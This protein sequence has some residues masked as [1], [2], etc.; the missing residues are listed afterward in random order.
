MGGL[1]GLVSLR[2]MLGNIGVTVIPNQVAVSN[3]FDAFD[4]SGNLKIEQ[5]TVFLKTTIEQFVSTTNAIVFSKRIG[6]RKV[7]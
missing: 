7:A 5:Q 6:E 3:G 2:M 4:D 1:R